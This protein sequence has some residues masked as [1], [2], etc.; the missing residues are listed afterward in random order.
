MAA[1]TKL[2]V[3]IWI[4]GGGFTAGVSTGYPAENLSAFGR[5]IVVTIN[6]RLAHMGYLRTN[7][8]FANFGLWDQHLAIKWVN[9]NI[10]SFGG[11]VNNISIFGESAGSSSV[12]YQ[13]LF[14]GN[15]GLF[16]RAIA[17]SGGITSS[18]AFSTNSNAENTFQNFTAEVGC[19]T[20]DKVAI[21]ACLRNKTT[22]GISNAI[23]SPTLSYTSIAPN[24]DNDFVPR[25]PFEMVLPT[26]A[27]QASLDTFYN[28]D[29][30]MGSCSIDG[31][32]FL[33][34]IALLT[35]A[36]INT[37]GLDN[38]KV[39]KID[40]ERDI[41]PA[42]LRMIFTNSANI[43]QTANNVAMYEYTNWTSP[44]DD[45]ARV[46]D[47][48][49]MYTDA[50]MN[51][52]MVAMSNLHA[53]GKRRS[54]MYRFSTAPTTNLLPVPSWL[55]SPTNANHADDFAFVFGFPSKGVKYWGTTERP[56]RYT[57]KDIHVSTV[58]MTMWTNFAKTG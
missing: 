40:F 22:D 19:T 20:G 31:A 7:E 42:A 23:R 38:L 47:L 37:G 55:Q 57:D 18:W 3:M 8:K 4:H 53:N 15:K 34:Y 50:D 26:M 43:P 54:Y 24:L 13:V 32:V 5:V 27:S 33:P 56:I 2:P 21:M 44:D 29:F 48:V 45:K 30:M 36:A 17:Q 6:Y 28:I 25:H 35:G 41:V 16:Q 14:P 46:K 58:V 51:A 10:D 39:P 52:P 1:G 12:V 9:Q 49:D 11:D